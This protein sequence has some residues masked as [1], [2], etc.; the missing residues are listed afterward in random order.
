MET[1][2][3]PAIRLAAVTEY[4]NEVLMKELA[5]LQE[6]TVKT[7]TETEIK[8]AC[9]VEH[10][11]RLKHHE[12]IVKRYEQFTRQYNNQHRDLNERHSQIIE[13]E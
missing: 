11:Q 4:C 3:D 1:E 12:D 13:Q 7:R 5:G 9:N 10:Q 6:D 8:E 2:A